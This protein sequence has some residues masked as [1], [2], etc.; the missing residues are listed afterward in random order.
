MPVET[1]RKRSVRRIYAPGTQKDDKEKTFI[2]LKITDEITFQDQVAP[3]QEWVLSFKNGLTDANRTVKVVEVGET[4]EK[5]KT[6]RVIDLGLT[7]QQG[8]R[9]EAIWSFLGNKQTPPLHLDTYKR[10]IYLSNESGEIID[11]DVWIE[12]ERI[13]AIEFADDYDDVRTQDYVWTLKHPDEQDEQD[14]Y[15]GTKDAIT[16]WDFSSINPPYRIDPFQTIVDCSFGKSLVVFYGDNKVA[17]VSISS[18]GKGQISVTSR[19]TLS[20]SNW[21]A[22]WNSKYFKTQQ[23]KLSSDQSIILSPLKGLPSGSVSYSD[24]FVLTSS[25]FKSEVVTDGLSSYENPFF[26][27]SATKIQMNCGSANV[28]SKGVFSGYSK[29][30]ATGVT[31]YQ[32]AWLVNNNGERW[33]GFSGDNSYTAVYGVTSIYLDWFSMLPSIGW[34]QRGYNE[35]PPPNDPSEAVPLNYYGYKY[36][37]YYSATDED[38]LSQYPESPLYGLEELPYT[39][40]DVMIFYKGGVPTYDYLAFNAYWYYEYGVNAY[41][42]KPSASIDV[43][44]PSFSRSNSVDSVSV[45]SSPLSSTGSHVSLDLFSSTSAKTATFQGVTY[46]ADFDWTYDIQSSDSSYDLNLVMWPFPKAG[47]KLWTYVRRFKFSA[48]ASSPGPDYTDGT[49]ILTT[50]YGSLNRT[51]EFHDGASV[52]EAFRTDPPVSF[53]PW[54][55]LSDGKNLIQACEFDNKRYIWINGVERSAQ[56]AAAI[57]CAVGDIRTMLFDVSISKLK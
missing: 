35:Y 32:L 1:S 28:D 4:G 36:Q 49:E 38:F 5:L 44:I 50:P 6:E 48:S 14:D 31:G 46:T 8:I 18:L 42:R 21:K 22:S 55:H 16:E 45:S 12:V 2:P 37:N 24:K 52:G 57:G 33:H 25:K 43:P 40:I 53:H 51:F 13:R 23:L 29:W 34:Q 39:A 30:T 17:S 19:R 26:C 54:L 9:Q 15:T 3:Y 41:S 47:D 27:G 56:L 10:K 7:E 11:R 20:Q